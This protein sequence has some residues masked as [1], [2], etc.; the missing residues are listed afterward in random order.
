MTLPTPPERRGP[1][2]APDGL[3]TRILAIDVG[4]GTQDILLWQPDQPI[5]NCVKLVLPSRTVIVAR[6]IARA[7]AAGNAV[8]LTGRLMGGGACASALKRHVAAGL[9]ASA[10]AEAAKT[11]RDN[12][13]EVRAKGIEILEDPP[14]GA[15]VVRTGDIDL[16]GLAQAMAPFEV[17]LPSR[18]AV[19]V[20]DHGE[21]LTGSNRRFRFSLWE[22]FLDAGGELE[23]LAYQDIPPEFTRMRAVQQMLPGAVLMDTGSAA[24]RGALQDETV[25]QAAEQGA[26][27]VNV[28][29][30]H[31]VGVLV[32]KERVWGLFEHHTGLMDPAK[33]V[34]H[35]ARLQLG[36][37]TNDE[38]FADHGHGAAV[39]DGAPLGTFG[40][41]AVTGPQRH[42]AQGTGWHFAVPYGDMMLSGPF[43]LVAAARPL[44]GD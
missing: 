44:L 33:L 10:T 19:C 4:G 17:T 38:V 43:G 29:N 8:H 37:L 18:Y 27:I 12:P 11:V 5:E 25:A 22:R 31:T 7:T 41:V 30:Q 26:T 34:D 40:F 9:K 36:T 14:I 32:M 15:V 21:C 6:R 28:G 13:D 2:L 1:G 3:D 23:D 39:V 24:I 16:D 35:V 42:M 20:Q